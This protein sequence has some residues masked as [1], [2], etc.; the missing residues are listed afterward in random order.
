MREAGR[1]D[2]TARELLVRAGAGDPEAFAELFAL[3]RPGIVALCRRMLVDA[4]AAEDAAS[5]VFLRAR[6]SLARYDAGRPFLPWLRSIAAN[7]CI[8]QLRRRRTE[9]GIFA[10]AE[11]SDELADEAPDA[12]ARITRSQER[13]TLLCA[14]DALPAKYRLPL[15][16]RFYRDLDYDAIAETLGV[17]RNQVATLLFRAKK[18]LRAR[19]TGDGTDEADARTGTGDE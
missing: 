6:R 17:S 5:E 14:I 3:H 12:L 15:V 13:E 7:H 4:S 19:L 10:A 18:R 2:A 16:L 1:D 9:R 8:D 11:R